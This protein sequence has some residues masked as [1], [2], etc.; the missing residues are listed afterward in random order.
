MKVIKRYFD[1]GGL[2]TLGTDRPY[3]QSNFLGFQM[4]GFSDHRELQL[5]SEAGIP[6]AE[7][8]RIATI[9][10]ARAIGISDRLGSI[11]I[12]KWGDL[13]IIKGDPISS[14]KNTRTVHT[15]IKGGVIYE[16][17][18]LLNAAK[19]KLGPVSASDWN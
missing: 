5:L 18:E 14:I 3:L 11:E 8:I 7:V 13:M 19:G 2:I 12:G 9:N 17:K 15:V 4:G 6:N 10:S 1:A 16:T